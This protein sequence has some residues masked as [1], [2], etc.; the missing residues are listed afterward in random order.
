VPPIAARFSTIAK[1]LPGQRLLQ[2]MRGADARE[3]G[4]DDQDV[5]RSV[6][7]RRW[8]GRRAGV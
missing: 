7:A 3:A 1:R 4:A 6:I 5:E 2:M 8:R